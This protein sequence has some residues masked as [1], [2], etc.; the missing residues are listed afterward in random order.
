MALNQEKKPISL[1][2]RAKIKPIILVPK[3]LKH[4]TVSLTTKNMTIVNLE[5][6]TDQTFKTTKAT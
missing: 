2:L 4:A 3:K 5:N 6:F 1:V